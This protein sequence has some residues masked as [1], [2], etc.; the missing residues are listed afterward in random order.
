[1]KTRRL[2][3][4][5]SILWIGFFSIIIGACQNEDVLSLKSKEQAARAANENSQVVAVT[6]EVLDV[7]DVILTSKNFPGGRVASGG[8]PDGDNEDSDDYESYDDEWKGCKPSVSG[9]FNVDRSFKDSLIYTGVFTIDYGDGSTCNAKHLRKGKVID[10]IKVAIGFKN[11]FSFKS[12]ETITFQGFYRDTIQLDGKFIVRSASG[13]PT[14]VEAQDA[15]ITYPDATTFTW[16]GILTLEYK[17]KGTR[18]CTGGTMK[19][20]EGT[21]TGTT[22]SGDDFTATITEEIVFKRC[23]GK[24]SFLPVSGAM[25]VTTNGVTSTID[26]GDGA[27]DKKYTITTGGN[28]TDHT[29]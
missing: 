28:T 18:H 23:F 5:R 15:K 3:S 25:D 21:L 24:R 8:D 13:E 20:T 22:R 19:I 12:T 2:Q 4:L 17:K 6:Q 1:M 9:S 29:F 27:C 11:S 7:T 26:F 16:E 10:S 14:T